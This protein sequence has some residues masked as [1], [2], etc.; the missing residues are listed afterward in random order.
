MAKDPAFLFYYQDFLV[1][2][3]EF[4]NEEVGAY[5]RCLCFQAAKG[6]IS[7]KHMKNICRTQSIHDTVKKK[8][9]FDSES[10][11]YK[12]G[13]LNE[14]IDKRRKYSESRSHNRSGK[15]T[16]TL[17]K[18]N[19]SSSYDRHMENENENINEDE[20]VDSRGGKGETQDQSDPIFNTE[21]LVP[22]MHKIWTSTFPLYTQDRMLDYPALK[23]IAGFIFKTSGVKNGFGDMELETKAVDTFQLIANEV[24]K[25][26][27][28]VNKPLVSISKNIQEFY[29]KIK[30]PINGSD[31]QASSRTSRVD[32]NSLQQKL[33]NRLAERRQAGSK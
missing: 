25:E 13:R 33:A 16:T 4:D 24:S 7:E 11:L 22:R 1:G 3:D 12:N 29:N 20:K 9:T 14:E 26:P 28:W 30:N 17:D 31:K 6:G 5:I 21:L 27:F 19:T 2:T 32:D 10:G 8:F 18:K 15:K 23:L